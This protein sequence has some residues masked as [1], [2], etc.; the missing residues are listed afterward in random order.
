MGSWVDTFDQDD[1]QDP[2][3]E[4]LARNDHTDPIGL[5]VRSSRA[6]PQVRVAV[7]R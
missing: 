1:P 4:L 6:G 2:L 5:L 7:V 3:Y